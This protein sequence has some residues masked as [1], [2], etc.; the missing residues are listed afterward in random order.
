MT[1]KV[2]SVQSPTSIMKLGLKLRAR[3]HIQAI[4][5]YS[6]YVTQRSFLNIRNLMSC[7]FGDKYV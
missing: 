3:V 1:S 7:Q 5:G 6:T 2:I 4:A